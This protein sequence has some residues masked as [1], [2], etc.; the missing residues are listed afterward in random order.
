VLER[1]CCQLVEWQR[2]DPCLSVA[3][4]LSVRQILATDIVGTVA[5]IFLRSRVRPDAVHLELTE[6]VLMG[7]T[8]YFEKTLTG[9]K[10]LGA[11]LAIDDFGTGYSSLSYL[12]RFPVD[13]VKIDRAFVDGLGVDRHNSALV[14]AIMGMA[15]AL[16]LSVTAEGI[17]TAGQLEILKQLGCERG[18][19]FYLARPMPAAD[20][21]RLVGRRYEI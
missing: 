6:G 2:R 16:E 7:D 17:E 3:V 19:G 14:A 11:Q 10:D 20:L 18:Q 1:A 13:S 4:N 12:H 9:L 21:S 8:E 15:E 5:D